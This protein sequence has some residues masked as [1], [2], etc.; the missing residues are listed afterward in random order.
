M[1]RLVTDFNKVLPNGGDG[2]MRLIEI[3]KGAGEI[4]VRTFTPGVPR[5]PE[6]RFRTDPNG[7]FV[8]EMDWATRFDGTHSRH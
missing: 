4:R 6:P 8:I 2:F 1:L 3:D 7:Q 5:R